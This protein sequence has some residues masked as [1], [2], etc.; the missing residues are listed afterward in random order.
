MLLFFFDVFVVPR[1]PSQS[2]AAKD[3][4]YGLSI[5]KPSEEEK[6]GAMLNAPVFHCLYLFCL[7]CFLFYPRHGVAF[8]GYGFCYI[9]L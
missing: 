6:T 7:F 1:K 9:V 2:A 3:E 5:D 4:L 8:I